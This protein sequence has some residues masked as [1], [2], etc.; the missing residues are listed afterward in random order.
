MSTPNVPNAVSLHASADVSAAT[1][2]VVTNAQNISGVTR[3]GAGIWVVTLATAL[4]FNDRKVTLTPNQAAG[5]TVQLDPAVQTDT[6]IGVLGFDLAVPG[7][8]DAA[9]QIK[10]DRVSVP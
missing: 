3:T 4:D 1:P 8:V 6:T 2:P 10:V 7:A 9:W 5:A